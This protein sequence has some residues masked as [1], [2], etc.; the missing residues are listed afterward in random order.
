MIFDVV[1]NKLF[2]DLLAGTVPAGDAKKLNGLTAEEF[3]SNDSLLKNGYFKDPVNSSGKTSWSGTTLVLGVDM[4]NFEATNASGWVMTLTD[5]GI[6]TTFDSDGAA[7]FVGMQQKIVLEAGEKYTLSFSVDGKIYTYRMTG[8]ADLS[9]GIRISDSPIYLFYL[10]GADT[11]FLRVY[12]SLCPTYTATINWAKLEAGSIATP[13]IPPN[14]EV[15]KLKCGASGFALLEDALASGLFEDQLRKTA[16]S[17]TFTFQNLCSREMVTFFT[18]WTDGTNFPR[19]YGSGVYIPCLD[20]SDATIIYESANRFFVAHV[21]KADGIWTP[22]WDEKASKADLANYLSLDGS[23]P[24]SGANLFVNGGTGLVRA[25]GNQIQLRAYSTAKDDNN[26]RALNL[27]SKAY[28]DD[29]KSAVILMDVINGT[30]TTYTVLHTGN[31]KKV[32]ITDSADDVPSE[33]SGLWAY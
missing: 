24:M 22:T 12:K 25:D 19:K 6:Q 18:N 2:K 31:S 11:I 20:S 10:S 5:S 17:D 21:E 9:G 8:K 33:M 23:V 1:T 13:F 30:P 32:A 28:K 3:V 7:R 14:K 15:E 27:I 29:V 26:C 16:I 4:W